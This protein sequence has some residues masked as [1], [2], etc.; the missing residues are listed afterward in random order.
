MRNLSKVI[1]IST[2]L[3]MPAY[4]AANKTPATNNRAEVERLELEVKQL[5]EELQRMRIQYIALQTQ[6]DS[7]RN[8]IGEKSNI[9]LNDS[10][11][12]DKQVCLT[13]LLELN[14][15][16][17]KLETLGYTDQHPD[18]KNVDRNIESLVLECGQTGDK[19]S[20]N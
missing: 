3:A 9:V 6:L 11:D 5:T 15:V 13:R 19:S 14:K 8:I 2:F 1:L 4:A 7:V 16:S 20:G 17:A 10:G 12:V 18:R